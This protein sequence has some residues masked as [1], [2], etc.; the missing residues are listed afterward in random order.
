MAQTKRKRQTKHRGNA[1]GK[2]EARGRT[3]RK[4]TGAERKGTS[5]DDA[6][7]RRLARLD[8]P[9]TWRGAMNRALIATGL[10]L[11]LLLLFFRGQQVGAKLGIAAFMLLLYVPLGYY[12]DLFIYRRRQARKLREQVARRDGGDA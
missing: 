2:V 7:A 8:Q 4:P 10:F 11:A 9:P 12:T 5:K 3:G 1:A 6:R